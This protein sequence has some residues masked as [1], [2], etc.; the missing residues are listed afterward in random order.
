MTQRQELIKT[1]I[2]TW[3]LDYEEDYGLS[4]CLRS[5]AMECI[6][7]IRDVTSAEFGDAAQALGLHRQGA[8]NR[9]NEVVAQGIQYVGE[10]A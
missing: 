5:A 8:R 10:A 1:A 3:R 9:F 6:E 4:D 2:T 7:N